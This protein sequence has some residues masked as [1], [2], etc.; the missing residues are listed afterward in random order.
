MKPIIAFDFD[1]TIIS[2]K[3][4]DQAH[5][6]W[7]E[8]LGFLLGKR[9]IVKLAGNKNYFKDVI[10]LMELVTGMNA[11]NPKE[12]ALMIRLARNLYQLLVLVAS[13]K[14]RKKLLIEGI[15]KLIEELK[16][17]YV[18]ALV[19][20]TPED[21]MLPLLR[22]LELDGLFDIVFLQPLS[23]MPDKHRLLKEFAKKH[24]KP[25]LFVGNSLP[26]MLACRALGIKAILVT[27]DY[28]DK[29]ALKIARYKAG[30]V[31]ELREL[32]KTI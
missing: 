17:A 16:T 10:K 13:R 9:K 26:D 1:G 8:L 32:I 14:Y 19:T 12:R 18:V 27:W 31:P 3:A 30:T 5:A 21:I 20:T 11:D 29:E 4:S 15:K 6:R 2:S 22:M 28:Y 25:E 23:E 24:K 7:Y